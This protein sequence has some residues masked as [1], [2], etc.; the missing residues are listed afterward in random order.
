MRL[1]FTVISA[2]RCYSVGG[3]PR[4]RAAEC[5]PDRRDGR[6]EQFDEAAF[7]AAVKDCRSVQVADGDRGCVCAFAALLCE[8]IVDICERSV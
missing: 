7:R 5:Y 3:L 2:G 6:G 8:H 4:V 1:T